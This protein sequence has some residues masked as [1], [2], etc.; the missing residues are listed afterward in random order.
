MRY[1]VIVAALKKKIIL[2]PIKGGLAGGPRP[3]WALMV[4]INEIQRAI[5]V[6]LQY[7]PMFQ[8]MY[9]IT[10]LYFQY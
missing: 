2:H 7:I 1:L 5:L 8:I 9:N 6:H 10:A 4:R 3:A